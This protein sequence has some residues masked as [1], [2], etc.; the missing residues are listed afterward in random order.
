MLR[1]VN[2][3][4][5]WFP[6]A[7][8]LDNAAVRQKVSASCGLPWRSSGA[9]AQRGTSLSSHACVNPLRWVWVFPLVRG[10][11]AVCVFVML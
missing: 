6:H 5:C 7:V 3:L 2:H 9:K 4:P 10:R 1:F 11:W 8:G